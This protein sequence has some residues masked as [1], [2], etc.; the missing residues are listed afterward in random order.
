MAE[1]IK[2]GVIGDPI[3]FEL[4]QNGEASIRVNI[5]SVI[6][7]AIS[8]KAKI[9]Q[10]DPYESNRRSE[11]NFGHTIGHGLEVLSNFQI[12]H[13]EAV[14]IGMVVETAFS[15]AIGL[16]QP[17]LQHLIA[18]VL[19]S[20]GL[21]VAIPDGLDRKTLLNIM[22]MDKKRAN[23]LLNF[24]LPVKIGEVKSGVFV[25]DL[26]EKLALA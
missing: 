6:S 20:S 2:H 22:Q 10:V 4:C 13:G 12:R 3:L 1:V 23:G 24:S 26:A 8:V 14:S 17:G 25:K 11:L 18:E 16:A 21:P 19:K 15:E 5:D 9:V 7:R